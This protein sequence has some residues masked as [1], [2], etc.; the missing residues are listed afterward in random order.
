[1]TT[2]QCKFSMLC[3]HYYTFLSEFLNNWKWEML[4]EEQNIQ[5]EHYIN[6]LKLLQANFEVN[7]FLFKNL[8]VNKK[9][10]DNKLHLLC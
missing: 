6:V 8:N 7:A 2:K 4:Y 9:K 10:I 5:W 3:G 1:M